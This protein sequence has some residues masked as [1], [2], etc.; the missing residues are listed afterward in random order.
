MTL[1][2]AYNGFFTSS[3]A[4]GYLSGLAGVFI[5]NLIGSFVFHHIT[6]SV[7]RYIIYAYIGISGILFLQS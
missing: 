5:G 4:T 6:G 1:A 3:V 2:R 7:L